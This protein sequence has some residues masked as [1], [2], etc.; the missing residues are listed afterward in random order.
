V[1][2]CLNAGAE[3]GAPALESS[4]VRYRRADH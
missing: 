4:Q 2:L 1:I 3:N